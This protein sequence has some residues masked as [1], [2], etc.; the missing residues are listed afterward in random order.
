L[1][2][3]CKDTESGI[4]YLELAGVICEKLLSPPSLPARKIEFI[5]NS[6]TCGTGMDLSEIPCE[7][8]VWYDQQN[9]WMSYAAL[10]ARTLD[11]QWHLT[12]VS[13]IGLIHSCCK[14]TI[15]MPQVFDK[16]N[17]R[18]DSGSWNFRLYHPDVVTICL[19]QNDGVQD[20]AVFCNAYMHFILRVRAVY[21]KAHIVCQTSPMGDG[22]LTAVQK[23]YLNG[24]VRAA[25]QAGDRRVSAY[26]YSRQYSRGCGG[27]PD[28]DEHRQIAEEL[29][30]YL[31]K[32]MRW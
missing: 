8:G 7:K 29:T 27:H 28:L 12:A 13:G 4:G 20:S 22:Y 16:M 3:I 15:T 1:V 25:G 11:A 9:A 6:I 5:G 26:F 31:K 14:M 19:G 30:D 23:R 18:N 24:I 21:P 10:T 2:T 17:Q 32:L